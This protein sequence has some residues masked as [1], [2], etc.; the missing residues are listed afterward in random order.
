MQ[1]NDVIIDLNLDHL[2]YDKY[3]G[4]SKKYI[5]LMFSLVDRFNMTNSIIFEANPKILLKLKE[6][7][8]NITVAV[9]IQDKEELEKIKD[10]FNDSQRVIYS[11][12]I[13][14]DEATVK[15]AVSLGKKVKVSLVDSQ[16]QVKNFK[17]G[18]LII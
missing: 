6:T 12:G 18:V 15:K 11:F 14:V 4:T 16:A 2:D 7:R 3:F 8:K 10:S 5:N 13:N 1:K 17:D 9:I